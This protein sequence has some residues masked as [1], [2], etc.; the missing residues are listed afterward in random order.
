V[1]ADRAA[2]GGIPKEVRVPVE[3]VLLSPVSVVIAMNTGIAMGGSGFRGGGSTAGMEVRR[4]VRVLM[5][6]AVGWGEVSTR[7]VTIMWD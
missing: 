1:G 4:F 5:K 3:G 7:T 6:I 2:V